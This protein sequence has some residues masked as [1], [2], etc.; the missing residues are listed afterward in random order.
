[1][2]LTIEPT[3]STPYELSS[4]HPTVS[5]SLPSDMLNLEEL[6]E[7]ALCPLLVGFGYPE[8][9]VRPRLIGEKLDTVEE[10]DPVVDEENYAKQLE[11]ANNLER[12][13]KWREGNYGEEFWSG[14]VTT[15]TVSLWLSLA[16]D[17]L[18]KNRPTR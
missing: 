7:H 17:F 6:I 3:E 18:R 8:L 12:Y 14:G 15:Y 5:V 10:P 1:M 11:L 9:L 16:T 13:N 2:K 4:T